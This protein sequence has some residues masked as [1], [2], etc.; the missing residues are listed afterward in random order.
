MHQP[1]FAGVQV[2]SLTLDAKLWTP[3]LN[4]VVLAIGNAQSNRW[5]CER[6]KETYWTRVWLSPFV[7]AV[8]Y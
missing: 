7:T 6:S 1:P 3:T 2:R 5:V 4:K 8:G